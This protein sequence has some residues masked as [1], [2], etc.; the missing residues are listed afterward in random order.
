M[1]EGDCPVKLKDAVE[2]NKNP[3]TLEDVVKET[4]L[5][6]AVEKKAVENCTIKTVVIDNTAAE[7]RIV[8]DQAFRVGD[9]T[10]DYGD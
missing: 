10:T 5:K 4:K 7:T 8:S 6:D 9:K 2:D 3:A 1:N